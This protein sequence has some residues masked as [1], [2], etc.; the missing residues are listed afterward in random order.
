MASVSARSRF[1]PFMIL[2][3]FMAWVTLWIWELSPYG[4]YLDHG[5]WTE[6]GLAASICRALPAGDI[7]LPAFLYIGGWVTMIAA[8]ML[9]TTLP[10]L[11]SFRRLNNRR[12]NR[13][14]LMGFLIAGYTV[15]W[16]LFGLAAHVLDWLL[17]ETIGGSPWLV[18]NGWV[19]GAIVFAVAGI[20]QFSALKYRCLE[21]CR[22]PI[23]FVLQYWR[24]GGGRLRAF[25]LGAYHGAYC[26]GCCWALMLLMFVLGT[27]SVGWM[28]LL[29]AVM[30]AEKNLP[31][32]QRFRAPVGYGL[33]ALSAGTIVY[34]S[35]MLVPLSS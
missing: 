23:G 16:L 33:I 26:V 30:A 14:Q 11:D 15:C 25:N 1:L 17:Y 20:F 28:L 19:L 10:L 32:G 9:P 34:H 31:F 4:R 29:A 35:G 6:L 5:R 2:L 21:K 7:V 22:A 3:V 27:G 8:M 12:E 13:W 18:V 24:N